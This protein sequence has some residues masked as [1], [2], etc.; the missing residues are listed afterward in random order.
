[1]NEGYEC[2]WHV[3][4]FDGEP[5]SYPAQWLAG[6]II[7]RISANTVVNANFL[8]NHDAFGGRVIWLQNIGMKD[9]PAWRDFLAEYSHA[10]RARPL[11]DRTVL[12]V[13]VVGRAATHPPAEDICL[14]CHIWRGTV[15]SLDMVLYCSSLL[16]DRDLPIV[17]KQVLVAVVAGLALW[18]PAV[19]E[20]LVSAEIDA[21]FEPRA[22]LKDIGSRRG[23]TG[24]V[25]PDN[26]E[27][28]CLGLTNTIDGVEKIHS[29]ALSFRDPSDDIRRRIWSAEVGVLFPYVENRRQDILKR[30][31]GLLRVPF[32]TRFG[33]IITDWRDLEIGHIESQIAMHGIPVGGETRRLLRRLRE[34]RNCLAHQEVV[35]MELLFSDAMP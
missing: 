26:E 16:R 20:E 29:A 28:W 31:A 11:M 10:C 1:M 33:E 15:D 23:W 21:I 27:G 4:S 22:I 13:A 34:I 5:G 19:A 14:A 6:R 12:C 7:P 32:E 9:W 24:E 8:A 30:L 18:D 3:I 35:P 2:P 17:R 25:A